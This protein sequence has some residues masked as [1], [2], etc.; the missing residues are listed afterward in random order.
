M[1][2]LVRIQAVDYT[3]VPPAKTTIS[4]RVLEANEEAAKRLQELADNLDPDVEYEVEIIRIPEGSS[5]PI[6]IATIIENLNDGV[7]TDY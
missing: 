5:T 2:H 4:T 7:L 6:E 1:Q 3:D